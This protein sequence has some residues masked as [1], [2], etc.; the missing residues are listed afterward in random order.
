MAASA[1][2]Q[3][4]FDARRYVRP[5][6]SAEEVQEIKEAFDLFDEKGNGS[7]DPRDLKNAM[8]QLGFEARNQT[9]YQMFSD[10]DR[11]HS[12]VIKFDE[13]L[14]MMTARLVSKDSKDDIKKVFALFDENQSGTISIENLERVSREIGEILTPQELQEMIRRIDTSGTGEVS[15]EDFYAMMVKKA[16]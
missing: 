9:I 8:L 14:D 5:G 2:R 16:D 10:L 4:S 12:H 11:Y 3:K 13:F 15:F 6:V 1:G 7:I